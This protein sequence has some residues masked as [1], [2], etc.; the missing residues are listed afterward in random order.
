MGYGKK[1]QKR[2]GKVVG[3]SSKEKRYGI[4]QDEY[5]HDKSFSG[6][7]DAECDEWTDNEEQ[8]KCHQHPQTSLCPT[9]LSPAYSVEYPDSFILGLFWQPWDLGV[10][11]GRRP[12]ETSAPYPQKWAS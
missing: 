8:A 11:A 9:S 2:K 12:E 7:Y 3:M 1:Q 10:H 6:V 4:V 5:I